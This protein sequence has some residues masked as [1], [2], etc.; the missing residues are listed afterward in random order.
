MKFR[1]GDEG[2]EQ[3]QWALNTCPNSVMLTDNNNLIVFM[4][5]SAVR[6]FRDHAN[7]FR[8]VNSQLR[9]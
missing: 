1:D 6:L 3:P 4:N 5:D 2:S 8:T 9:S 7:D